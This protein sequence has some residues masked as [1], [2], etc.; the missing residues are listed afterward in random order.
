MTAPLPV[1]LYKL[2]Q[3]EKL[4]LVEDLWDDILVNPADIPLYNWQ[5]TELEQRKTALLDKPVSALS[6]EQLQQKIRKQHAG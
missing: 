2:S 3:A 4:Q 1:S 5:K 6:W